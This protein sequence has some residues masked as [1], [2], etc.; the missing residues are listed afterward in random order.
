MYN[1]II[2]VRLVKSAKSNGLITHPVLGLKKHPELCQSCYGLKRMIFWPIEKPD[3]LANFIERRGK[4]SS[5]TAITMA[6]P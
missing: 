1:V 5:P 3:L 2:R 6:V 4:I